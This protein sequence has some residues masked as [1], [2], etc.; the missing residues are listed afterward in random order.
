MLLPPACAGCG[1]YGSAL[2][3]ECVATFVAPSSDDERFLVADAGV[4]LGESLTVAVAA[5][6]YEATLRRVLGRVKYASAARVTGIL[7]S[8]A[9][10]AFGALTALTGPAAVVPVPLHGRRHRE[11]GFNQ[12]ALIGAALARD[13]GLE[14]SD[15]LVR[16]RETARQHGLDRAAR[17]R[18]LAAAF[19]VA[20]GQAIPAVAILVDD[21]LTT[22]ATMEACASVLLGAGSEQVY[23]FA[24]AREV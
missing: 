14:L 15:V 5:F 17:V 8:S 22:A 2:C 6:A 4:V 19:Q 24:L 23:G 10:P 21:I 1:R 7:A 16:V 12:A 9:R 3:D 18:N 13:S 11:R 20:P